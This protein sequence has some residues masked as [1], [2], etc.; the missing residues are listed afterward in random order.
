MSKSN[1][2]KSGN[3]EAS[4]LFT[5]SETECSI[6]MEKLLYPC[7]LECGHIFCYLCIK[8]FVNHSG[9]CALCRA[10]VS[11]DYLKA[12]HLVSMENEAVK[13]RSRKHVWYYE[14]RNGWWEYD[15]RTNIEIEN[16]YKMDKKKKFQLLISGLIYVI[17]F[18]NK[19]QYRLDDP[20][21][22]RR[23]KRDLKNLNTRKGVAGIFIAS[24]N[25]SE[26]DNIN[27]INQD[28]DTS[29]LSSQLNKMNFNKDNNQS[30]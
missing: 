30:K 8:G 3:A 2:G 11:M 5:S 12:P 19:L 27:F 7:Q 15:S 1:M 6:C 20:S 10:A 9:K 17:D 22:K 4:S 29:S 16:E 26:S 25:N 21:K 13:T 18:E 28:T 24:N 14:G 23:I